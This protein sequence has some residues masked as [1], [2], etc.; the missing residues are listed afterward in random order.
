MLTGQLAIITAALFSGAA[1]CVNLAEQH[2]RLSLDDQALLDEW[3]PSYRR[4]YIMQASF[5]ILGCI[6]GAIARKHR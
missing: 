4:G 2:A 1:V 3:K 5:A 6:L